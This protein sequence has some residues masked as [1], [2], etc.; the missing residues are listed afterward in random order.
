[1]YMKTCCYNRSLLRMNHI[2]NYKV[3]HTNIYI[4]IYLVLFDYSW[5]CPH[6]LPL[7]HRWWNRGLWPPTHHKDGAKNVHVEYYMHGRNSN[8]NHE[9]STRAFC[10]ICQTFPPPMLWITFVL[11]LIPFHGISLET[12]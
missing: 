10:P 1:M 11:S 12:T 3:L 2:E 8:I 9:F 7:V 4:Y 5:R 6:F